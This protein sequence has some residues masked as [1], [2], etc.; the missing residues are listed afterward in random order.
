MERRGTL[1]AK[2]KRKFNYHDDRYVAVNLEND[3]S[4]ELRI[5][6][7]TLKPS[8]F[9]KSIEYSHALYT[10]SQCAALPRLGADSFVEWITP[11][12]KTYPNLIAFLGTHETLTN[13][14]PDRDCDDDDDDD[15][16]PEGNERRWFFCNGEPLAGRASNE[17]LNQ[18][19]GPE[20]RMAH[21]GNGFPILVIPCS[22]GCGAWRERDPAPD[23]V[24]RLFTGDQVEVVEAREPICN[25]A[26][27]PQ[28]V[29]T[30]RAV[31]PDIDNPRAP[32]FR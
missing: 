3:A 14:E 22:C 10:Y 12:R 27:P 23:T 31:D 25:S 1:A 11:Q 28:T 13:Y 4:V 21:D 32:L 16:D 2:A 18:G 9:M 20:V 5:F 24:P 19:G 30:L 26:L 15:Q 17:T 6:R 29:A 8:S 7:G